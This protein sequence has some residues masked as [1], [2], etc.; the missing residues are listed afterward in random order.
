[1][2]ST[3]S[4]FAKSSASQPSG[5]T[6]ATFS[7]Q[8]APVPGVSVPDRAVALTWPAVTSTRPVKYVVLRTDSNG[9]STNVCTGSNAPVTTNSTVSCIDTTALSDA[10]YSYSEQPYLDILN[11][12]PWSLPMSARSPSVLTPRLVYIGSGPD[13]STTGATVSVPY[14][15]GTLPGDLL[16]LISVSAINKTMGTPAGWTLLVNKGLPGSSSVYLTISWSVAASA[17]SVLFNPQSNGPGV[18]VRVVNYGRFATNTVNPAPAG[19]TI[20]GSCSAVITCSPT[21]DITTTASDAAVISVVATTAANSPA[22]SAP[23]AFTLRDS[24][25]LI[26]GSTFVSMGFA[27]MRVPLTGGPALSPTWVQSGTTQAWVYAT[28]AFR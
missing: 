6:G 26:A 1:M 7:P 23:Q 22:L 25:N 21:P 12:T 24:K 19:V 9:T 14:P 16:L 10:T 27:D 13:V 3:S 2:P 17:T 20:T 8:V 28:F 15:A 5:F 11:S 18:S 4:L